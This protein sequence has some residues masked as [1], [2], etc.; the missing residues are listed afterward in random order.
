MKIFVQ[1][2]LQS[3][4]FSRLFYVLNFIFNS[5]GIYPEFIKNSEKADLEIIYGKFEPETNSISIFKS[6]QLYSFLDFNK[7]INRL[8]FENF[9][10]KVLGNINKSKDAVSWNFGKT[11]LGLN[12]ANINFDLIA[13]I[14]YHLMRVEEET[15]VKDLHNRF[16]SSESILNELGGLENP[17]INVYLNFFIKLL[18]KILLIVVVKEQFPKNETFGVV[19]THDVDR[20]KKF[21]FKQTVKN[22]LTGRLIKHFTENKNSWNFEKVVDFELSHN[23]K[24]A[25][26]FLTEAKDRNR[27]RYKIKSAKIRDLVCELN[28]SEFEIGLHSSYFCDEKNVYT[29]EKETIEKIIGTEINGVRNHYL[30]ATFP[31]TWQKMAQANFSYDTTLGFSQNIGFRS[32]FAGLYNVFLEEHFSLVEIPLTL[33]DGFLKPVNEENINEKLDFLEKFVNHVEEF[34]GT[35]CLLWHQSVWEREEYGLLGELYE[36]FVDFCVKKNAFIGAPKKFLDWKHE[37]ESFQVV[38]AEIIDGKAEILCIPQ[39]STDFITLRFYFGKA[40]IGEIETVN[41]SI[42]DVFYD[43]IYLRIRLKSVKNGQ[44]IRL[45][46]ELKE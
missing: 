45:K 43:W 36:K 5:I 7:Q 4:D 27:Y 17:I 34:K 42:D 33:M 15:G 20:I 44:K 12:C 21:G 3:N 19:L 25:F 46:I 35:I 30:R 39:K 29:K 38:S 41:A 6:Q 16:Q 11:Q 1:T 18:E 2:D 13:N 24:S 9:D 8:A 32:G 26:Y 10:F 31:Q 22:I 28:V 37:R 40:E 23:V 14:Y